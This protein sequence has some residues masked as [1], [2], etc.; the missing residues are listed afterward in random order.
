MI[1]TT[2]MMVFGLCM[3]ALPATRM[4]AQ[5]TGSV[6]GSVLADGSVHPVE[7]VLVFVAGTSVRTTTD[8]SG[9]FCV[10]LAPGRHQLVFTRIGCARE[11][12]TVLI[13]AGT[14]LSLNVVVRMT[15]LAFGEESVVVARADARSPDATSV[16]VIGRDAITHTQPSSLADVLQLLPGRAAENPSLSSPQQ[17]VLR[18][19]RSTSAGERA[20]AMGTA[21]I[22]DGVPISNNANMQV[23]IPIL[24]SSPDALPAFASVAGRGLDLRA[25]GTDNIEAIEILQGIASARFGDLTSGAIM[26][27]TRASAAPLQVS[28]RHNVRTFELGLGRGWSPARST[29]LA[30]DLNFAT[31]QEDPR[32]PY[33]GFDRFT[34]QVS[35]T[36]DWDEAAVIS[37]TA[38]VAAFST[39]DE[40]HQSPDD[41]R[42]QREHRSSDRGIRCALTT[43]LRPADPFQP[44]LSFTAS[45]TAARQASSTQE[46]ITRDVFPIALA[47]AD[48][49]AP[50]VFGT[51][52]YLGKLTVASEP[53]S[54]YM[55]LEG[56]WRVAHVAGITVFTM[57]GEWRSEGTSGEGRQFDILR[58][59]RQNYSVGER[60]RSYDDLPRIDVVSGY[61]EARMALTLFGRDVVFQ[62]GL[63][64]DN[65][66]P[67]G[68]ARG[69]FGTRLSPRLVVTHE[70]FDGLWLRAGY[71]EM[72]KTP[73]LSFLA[74]LPRYFDIVNLNYFATDPRER[75]TV[76]TTRVLNIGSGSMTSSRSIKRELGMEWASG[77]FT[78]SLAAYDEDLTG[79]FGMNR[80]LAVYPYDRYQAVPQ[81]A[82]VPPAYVVA[83]RDTFMGA[84]DA[85]VNSVAV[86]TR[87][88]EWTIQTPE[89][90]NLNVAFHIT[91]AYVRTRSEDRSIQADAD[92]LFR[93]SAAPPRVGLFPGGQGYESTLL[94]TSVRLILRQ[95]RW[96]LI[97][98]LLAQ[99][100]WRDSDRPVGRT[101]DPIGYVDRSG[102]VTFLT[103][104]EVARPEYDDIRRVISAETLLE[105]PRTDPLWLFNMRL[106]KELP[107]DTRLTLFINNVLADRPLYLSVR[108]NTYQRRNPALFFGIELSAIMGGLL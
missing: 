20:N 88:I 24:N 14:T 108:S 42:Y 90:P 57:G 75:L 78:G 21:I 3:A 71:G 54:G 40:V 26:V 15:S 1:K 6:C 66:E 94:R 34:T 33:E 8:S 60:P 68:L 70:P 83:R 43:S 74:P 2:L 102:A 49:T 87:G 91:G 84:Y 55:R 67:V 82:G 12:R 41:L 28:L 51:A 81:E 25:V 18:Q 45:V 95:P 86:R 80:F 103:P 97:L 35:L 37:S 32:N 61:G 53:V 56:R 31:S 36:H 39:V 100:T 64:F 13:T 16:A 47:R 52:T 73:P 23:D 77:G 105:E 11:T 72:A 46:L 62:G 92:L 101:S 4:I 17:A 89:L 104:E 30:A 9:R 48:T 7:D 79:G 29:V 27:T 96:G 38:R 19:T 22:I 5:E 59:P 44:S 93:G 65:V 69:R 99:T 63:R 106:T 98:S 76:L 85:P 50:G 58:P 10:V 107:F